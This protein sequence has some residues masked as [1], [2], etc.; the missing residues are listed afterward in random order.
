[1]FQLSSLRMSS[2]LLLLEC[3]VRTVLAT[4]SDCDVRWVLGMGRRA[5]QYSVIVTEC[6]ESLPGFQIHVNTFVSCDKGFHS[7]IT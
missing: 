3:F 6:F 2:F 1:M 4:S 7:R 5:E